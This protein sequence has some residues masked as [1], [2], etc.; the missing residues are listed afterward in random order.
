M[1]T[2][3]RLAA[4][5]D[6]RKGADPEASWTSKLLSMGPEKAAEKFGDGAN[7]AMEDTVRRLEE[8]RREQSQSIIVP[9]AGAGAVPGAGKIQMP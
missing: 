1:N 9:E 3:E 5:I 6:R 2:L 7:Q 8:M 4:T